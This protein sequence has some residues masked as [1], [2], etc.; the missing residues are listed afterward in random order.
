[1]DRY[2]SIQTDN[3][4]TDGIAEALLRTVIEYGRVAMD[5]P[6]DLKA[7]SE[8]MWC[9]SLSH[10]GLTGLGQPKDF[11]AHALGHELSGMFDVPHGESL[12]I[13]WP[14]WA[15]Y[16]YRMPPAGS[17]A[18]PECLGYPGGDEERA[19]LEAI[20]A[21]EQYFSHVLKLPICFSQPMG[22]QT[23]RPSG[24]GFCAPPTMAAAGGTAPSNGEGRDLSG[25]PAGQPLRKAQRRPYGRRCRLIV[26]PSRS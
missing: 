3:A 25:L 22:V 13:M 24:P 4:L 21:T 10:D 11:S 1:M 14:A 20:R 26:S 8:I 9:G 23:R 5:K 15:R 19:A 16:V 18:L 6:E 12:S 2:F 7:R 17:P